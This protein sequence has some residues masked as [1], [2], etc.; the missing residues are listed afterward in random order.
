MPQIESIGSYLPP[1]AG[2]A[3]RIAGPDEDAITLA[4]A[5]G[6]EALNGREVDRVVLVTR[7]HPLI[8][9][10][11]AAVLLAGLGLSPGAEVVERNGGAAAALDAVTGAAPGTLVI[12]SDTGAGGEPAGAAAALVTDA[13]GGLELQAGV[14]M[15]RSLPVRARGADGVTH[16]YDDPRLLRDRGLAET[17]RRVGEIAKPVALAGGTAA[18]ARSACGDTAPELPTVGASAS[19]FALAALAESGAGGTVLAAD[20]A[21]LSSAVLTGSGAAVVRRAERAARP[22]PASRRTDGPPIPISL[23]AYDRAFTPKLTLHAGRSA[24]GTLTFP[25]RR[26]LTDGSEPELVA[27]PRT[28]SVYTTTMINVPV[29]GMA[30]PYALVIAEL[31]DVGVRVLARVTGWEADRVAIG[32]RGRLVFRRVAVR[33]GIPDYGY[34]FLPDEPDEPGLSDVSGSGENEEQSA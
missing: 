21:S 27:L 17:L 30:T 19:L 18:Q 25:P 8:E 1:W 6:R 28:G 15:A 24:D 7:D 33:S 20:Q 10:G 13:P 31:D 22:A 14:R 26:G 11:S 4:V 5:A 23:P 9:G 16:D 32:D 29:P 2:R 12:G 34:A 3:G